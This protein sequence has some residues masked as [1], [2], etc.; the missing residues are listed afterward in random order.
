MLEIII[1]FIVFVG[2]FFH[3]IMPRFIGQERM[4]DISEKDILNNKEKNKFHFTSFDGLMLTGKISYSNSK[5][6]KG[7]IILLHGIGSGRMIY[8]FIVK[9]LNQNGYNTIAFDLR[10]HNESQGKYSTYG[11]K[12]KKD[13]QFL[14]DFIDKEYNIK[15]NIGIWGKSLGAAVALQTMEIDERIQFGVIE[16]TFSNFRQIVHDYFEFHL[17]FDVY[18]ITEYFIKRYGKFA[19]F[20]PDFSKPIDSCK[21][22]EKPILVVH[23]DLDKRIKM[24]YGKANFETLKNEQNEFLEIKGANHL[25]VWEIGGQNY[26]NE[27]L[28]FLDKVSQKSEVEKITA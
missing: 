23:G 12:E 15:E 6:T 8:D 2:I 17:G 13:I 19:D 25:N 26:L 22:I 14:L 24:K 9:F 10:A 18:P 20:N 4:F 7:T 27:V 16:S 28:K 3:F 1:L 11:V 21:K 5:E